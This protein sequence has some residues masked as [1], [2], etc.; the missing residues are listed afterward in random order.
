VRL[1]LVGAESVAAE[2]SCAAVFANGAED[3]DGL[4]VPKGESVE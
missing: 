1:A 2:M 3:N 4:A